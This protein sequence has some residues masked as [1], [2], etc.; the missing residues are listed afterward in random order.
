MKNEIG[1]NIKLG[2]YSG[3]NCSIDLFRLLCAIFVVAIHTKL[4]FDINPILGYSVKHAITRIAVPFFF[5]V[6]GFY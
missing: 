2:T 3:R 1:N 6:M 5:C 4:F